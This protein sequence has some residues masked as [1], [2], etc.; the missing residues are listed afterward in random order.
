MEASP[1][2]KLIL[3]H[4][5]VA[6]GRTP[7]AP[8]SHDMKTAV[9]Q[10]KEWCGSVN[11]GAAV[12]YFFRQYALFITAQFDLIVNHGCYFKGSF[13]DLRFN[14]VRNYGFPLLETHAAPE[15]LAMISD[16]GRFAAMHEVLYEQA[17][18][19]IQEFRRYVKISPIIL[20]ENILGSLLWFYANFEK[21]QPRRAA[22]DLEW[23]LETENWKPIKTS[24]LAKLLGNSSLE[25]AVTR[26]LRKTCCLY[27]E[28]DAFE[29]CTFC[30]QPHLHKNA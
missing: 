28:L 24:Y 7:E 9:L 20:W 2:L 21:R 3:A 11:D 13:S 30:P 10:L 15:H 16:T 23:L 27:K 19:A 8:L 29:T 5:S 18:R 17:D 1:E 25:A 6:A 26:P 14:Q 22:E 4:Y 12:S